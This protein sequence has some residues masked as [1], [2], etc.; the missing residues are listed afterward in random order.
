[1]RSERRT[2]F[3][4][5]DSEK[6]RDVF[7]LGAGFSR[8]ISHAMPLMA[9]LTMAIKEHLKNVANPFE[10][11]AIPYLET[12]FEKGL[13]YLAEAQPWLS[14]A[15]H[16]RNRALF[17]DISEAVHKVLVDAQRHAL[18]EQ[19]DCPEWLRLLSY[20]MHFGEVIVLTLNY[21]T[22]LE[23]ALCELYLGKAGAYGS[24]Y[25]RAFGF[26]AKQGAIGSA[27]MKTLHLL[28]LHG[29]LH[30]AYSGSDH[31]FGEAIQD[32]QISRWSMAAGNY[33]AFSPED[34]RVPLIVPP[35][36]NKG[37][38]FENEKIR[39]VWTLASLG[40]RY[41]Q[42]VFCVGYSLPEGDLLMHFL[43]H[44]SRPRLDKVPFY[45]V[46]LDGNSPEHYRKALPPW[47]KLDATFASASDITVVESFARAL[48]S[49][50]LVSSSTEI[51]A[52]PSATVR[53]LV[54]E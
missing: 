21:D 38:Y 17:L 41:A 32:S 25:L 12:D 26:P 43:L 6:E 2:Y 35:T 34:G 37:R 10:L 24:D 20:W 39:S 53:N 27:Q 9:E 22:L 47:Y 52:G 16:L 45:L 5:F 54:R 48:V 30:W 44:D 49:G 33:R 31:Y 1:M 29:S 18:Q 4:G 13:S 23:M 15:E 51:V 11:A 46:N 14:E 50:S 3:P 36:L 7:L 28:K 8:S 19:H 40:L 42:R